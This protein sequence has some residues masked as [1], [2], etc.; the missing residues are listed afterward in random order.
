MGFFQPS[1]IRNRRGFFGETA[2]AAPFNPASISGLKLWLKADAGVTVDGSN[3]V[4]QWSDQSVSGYNFVPDFPT[5]DITKTASHASFNSQPVITFVTSNNDGDV[6]LFVNSPFTSRSGFVAYKLNSVGSFEYSVPYENS[7]INLYTSYDYNNRLFG[8][9]FNGF[10]DSNTPSELGQAY[11]RACLSD[12]IYN[13]QTEEE[14]NPINFFLGLTADGSH[15]GAGFFDRTAIVIGN[16]SARL[17]LEGGFLNQP[18]EG[19][20][21]EILAYD[22]VVSSADRIAITNYLKNKY[23]I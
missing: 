18:F 14:E 22:E 11:V 10:F 17:A 13:E 1:G 2:A 12:S 3:R 8:G 20:L 21:A 23:N 9:Y 16:G 4:T 7:G 19:D 15:N 5:L 6:G